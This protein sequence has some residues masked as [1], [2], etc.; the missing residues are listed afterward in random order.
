[1]R[2]NRVDTTGEWCLSRIDRDDHRAMLTRLRSI[3]SMSVNEVF[4]GGDEPGKHYDV[5]ECPNV[6]MLGRLL[7]LECDDETRISR[8]RFGGKAR[9]FGFLRGNTFYALW[10]DPKHEIWPSLKRR[11]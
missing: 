10:W 4:H 2:F 5:G 11:T 3:E 6:A 1:M 9:L 7:E 8:I